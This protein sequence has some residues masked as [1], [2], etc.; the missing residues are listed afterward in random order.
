[1]QKAQQNARKYKQHTMP[2]GTIRKVQGYEP[3]ALHD[4]LKSYKE[5]DIKTDRKD[6][7]RIAYQKDGK[8]KYYFPDIYLPS[9]NTIIE[10]KSTW[11][12]RSKTDN[13]IEKEDATKAAGYNYDIWIYDAK[14]NR[15]EREKIE[16][17]RPVK[18]S[19]PLLP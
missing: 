12:Y 10:V 16:I 13:I 6:I 9:I 14:G 3:F 8:D 17:H 1:M 2:S 7:P 19:Q 15:M 5:D 18:Q 4:L 11:T